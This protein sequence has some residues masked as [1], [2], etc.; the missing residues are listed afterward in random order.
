M[1]RPKSPNSAKTTAAPSNIRNHR[2][3]G[4]T[5]AGF[6]GKRVGVARTRLEPNDGMDVGRMILTT[7][8]CRSPV[9]GESTMG[10]LEAEI[11]CSA[12]RLISVSSI[13]ENPVLKCIAG[14]FN[15]FSLH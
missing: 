12:R 2:S 6:S 14:Y 3:T 9:R 8:F 4:C 11:N 1:Y 13:T 10:K 5:V 7:P 15:I